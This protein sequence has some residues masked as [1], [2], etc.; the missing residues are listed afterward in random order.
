MWHGLMEN[1]SGLLVNASLT[2]ADGQAE[3]MAAL[4]MIEPQADRSRRITPGADKGFDR[5]DFFNE[6]RSMGIAPRVTRNAG[7]GRSTGRATRH[8][9][10]AVSQRSRKR[11]E[12]D[13]G[14]TKTFAGQSMTKFRGLDRVGWAFTF[15]AAV[16]KLV[17]LPKLLA[18]SVP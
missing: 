3:R 7:V 18:G 11:I 16:Y 9:G 2:R 5:Q 12:E 8:R 6:L 10:Y 15:A 13:F 14:C 4:L 17:R 1:R